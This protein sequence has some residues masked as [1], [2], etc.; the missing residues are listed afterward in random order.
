MEIHSLSLPF[1]KNNATLLLSSLQHPETLP[2]AHY[3]VCTPFSPT[4]CRRTRPGTLA[5]ALP[6]GLT[7]LRLAWAAP[8]EGNHGTPLSEKKCN[9]NTA[10]PT[11]D[12]VW[13]GQGTGPGY[14]QNWS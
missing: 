10:L 4:G 3:N 14:T 13:V 12:S 8:S 2:P 9:A 6:C 11:E 5:L 1:P 7:G